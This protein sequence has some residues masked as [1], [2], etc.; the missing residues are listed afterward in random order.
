MVLV[1]LVFVRV[2]VIVVLRLCNVYGLNLVGSN[3]FNCVL[4]W[5]CLLMGVLLFVVKIRLDCLCLGRVVIVVFERC[6]M[7]VFLFLVCD[8]VLVIVWVLRL[9]LDYCKFVILDICCFVSINSLNVFVNGFERLLSVCYMVC[10]FLIDRMI[11]C[12][13]FLLVFIKWVLRFVLVYFC[14]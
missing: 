6:V 10:I 11:L 5:E 1:C 8:L 2:V 4:V 7:C 3:L 12:G 13:V 14:W 9:I